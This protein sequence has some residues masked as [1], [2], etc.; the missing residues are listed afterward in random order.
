MAGHFILKSITFSDLQVARQMGGTWSTL[1]HG[2]VGWTR[3]S[4]RVLGQ[5]LSG[6]AIGNR[7]GLPPHRYL[8]FSAGNGDRIEEYLKGAGWADGLIRPDSPGLGL[9]ALIAAAAATWPGNKNLAL[10][11]QRQHGSISVEV[12]YL[13]GETMS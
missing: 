7:D 10:V 6:Q 5:A 13:G 12:Y 11:A 3:E 9:R 4:T 8:Q 2:Y 1:Q